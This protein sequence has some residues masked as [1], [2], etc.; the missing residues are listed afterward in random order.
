MKPSH[1]DLIERYFD[2]G[3]A[4]DELRVLETL[5]LENP[6]VREEF[7]VFGNMEGSLQEWGAARTTE[8]RHALIAEIRKASA[9]RH[10]RRRAVFCLA[11]AALLALGLWA[12]LRGPGVWK[13]RPSIVT[14]DI[15]PD[16]VLGTSHAIATFR[17]GALVS[18]D[19]RAV[20]E[21]LERGGYRLPTGT[22]A[23][24]TVEGTQVSCMAPAG[25][26]LPD[27]R[28][29]A[30]SEGI[31]L[32]RHPAMPG[33]LRITAG[34]MSFSLEEGECVMRVSRSSCEVLLESGRMIEGTG[35]P[36]LGIGRATLFREGGLA[37]E[38]P[39][40]GPL[41]EVGARL[42]KDT[43][44]RSNSGGVL[45]SLLD[46]PALVIC[47]DFEPDPADAS[48]VVNRARRGS[49]QRDGIVIGATSAP[50]RRRSGQVMEFS[51]HTDRIRL[52]ADIEST[53]LTFAAWVLVT[54]LDRRYNSLFMSDDFLPGGVHWQ[55]G[56]AGYLGLCSRVDSYYQDAKTPPIIG[57]VNYG[58]WHHLA[59]TCN[60]VT[61]EVSHYLDGRIISSS[62]FNGI[63]T[64]HFVTAE[65]GNW[66]PANLEGIEAEIIRNFMGK[67]DDF[68]LF[69]R[70]L[71]SDEIAS[72]A[73]EK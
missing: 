73:R 41:R 62:R 43:F 45:P 49:R 6:A 51:H 71:S 1:T 52:R 63:P 50:D 65:I 24:E 55:M 68:C 21:T 12:G 38:V 70:V 35:G 15:S 26:S 64:F 19:G 48:R 23:L 47:Y 59:T 72:L 53:E 67:M 69:T 16:S 56:N 8:S 7:L 42:R 22:A 37:E 27:S 2:G 61:G 54:G 66:R 34:G 36:L 11:A 57:P 5:L 40:A 60:A 4:S 46:D 9:R 33:I 10:L 29:I 18:M 30:L 3:L 58:E 17:G 20:G 32:I 28:Q 13:E 39:D 31:F 44:A 25:F 14:A